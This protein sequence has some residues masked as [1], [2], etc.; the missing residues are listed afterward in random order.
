VS[1]AKAEIIFP[2]KLMDKLAAMEYEVKG[3]MEDTLKAGAAVVLPIAKEYLQSAIGNTKYPS[4][5]TGELLSKLGTSPVKVSREGDGYDIRIGFAEPRQA[6]GGTRKLKGGGTASA[7]ALVGSVLEF[8]K[9]GQPARPFMAPAKSASRA[10]AK[11][12]MVDFADKAFEGKM[13]V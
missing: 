10:K 6:K 13:K 3:I 4:R 5:S 11:K 2:T 1:V 12:A 9:H 8:G 7:N